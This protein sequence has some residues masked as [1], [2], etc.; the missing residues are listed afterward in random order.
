VGICFAYLLGG[1]EFGIRISNVSFLFG[2][3]CDSYLAVP[4]KGVITL[5]CG[6]KKRKKKISKHKR[7]KRMRKDRHKKKRK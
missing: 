5:P 2:R 4:W 6:R 3:G 7:K 1:R